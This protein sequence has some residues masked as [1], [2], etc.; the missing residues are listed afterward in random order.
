MYYCRRIFYF[1]ASRIVALATSRRSPTA[2]TCLAPNALLQRRRP[3][4][5]NFMRRSIRSSRPCFEAKRSR[6]P[7][8]RA[9]RGMA[10]RSRRVGSK[11][12]FVSGSGPWRTF[13]FEREREGDGE[14]EREST[15]IGYR[16]LGNTT[17]PALTASWPVD[18]EQFDSS[19]GQI[20]VCF[21]FHRGFCNS[22]RT[23]TANYHHGM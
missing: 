9:V 3:T 20:P 14:R 8:S 11:T 17:K 5:V 6:P 12:F 19:V 18:S 22:Q 21:C 16:G 2:G 1:S 7:A 10:I 15:L 13:Q 4:H 23:T